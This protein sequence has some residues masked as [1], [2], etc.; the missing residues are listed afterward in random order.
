MSSP[1]YRART[2]LQSLVNVLR[3]EFPP[4]RHRTNLNE[5]CRIFDAI[6]EDLERRPTVEEP[7]DPHSP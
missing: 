3:T 1:A 2:Y 6:L 7:N 5:I 4:D